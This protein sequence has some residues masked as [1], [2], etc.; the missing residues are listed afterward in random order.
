MIVYIDVLIFTNII[1]NYCILS[2]TKIFIHNNNSE[3]RTILAAVLGSL[4]SLVVFFP[5]LNFFYSLVLKLVC[6]A[7]MCFISFGFKNIRVF[8]KSIIMVFVYTIIFCS[9][10]ITVYNIFKPQNMAIINDTV[11]FQIDSVLLILLTIITYLVILLIQKLFSQNFTN[12][13]V[14][15]KIK[16]QNKE[17]TCIGKIDTACSLSEPFSGSPVIIVEK[18]IFKDSN[19]KSERVIPYNSLGN[20][21]ILYGV[22]AESVVIDSKIIDKD[23]YIGIYNSKVDPSFNAII[24]HNI[25]R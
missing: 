14:N 2:A 21:G 7:T 19:I 23:I 6:S 4:F 24:N 17:Y 9:A 22:K 8:L 5:K 10:M 13:L 18:E 12:T 20:S 11:Y 25:L 1:I 15:L 3:W 16:L